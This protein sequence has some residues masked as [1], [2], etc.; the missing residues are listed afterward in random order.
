MGVHR[1]LAISNESRNLSAVRTAV[2]EI[3]EQSPFDSTMRN[4]IIVAVDEALAN[5]VEHAYQGGTG[6]I[7]ILFDMDAERLIVTIRDNGVR[8]H[9]GERLTAEIDI[10]EHI[11]QGLKGGLGLFLMKQIMDE[12][13]FNQDPEASTNELVLIKNLPTPGGDEAAQG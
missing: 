11:R 12:V 3:L 2:S 1:E 13:H 8:F 10:H 4:K 7:W 9:P 6:D 5:V